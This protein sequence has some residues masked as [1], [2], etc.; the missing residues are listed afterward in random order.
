M[1]V[2]ISWSGEPSR[3]VALFL[4]SWLPDLVQ[5][6]DPWMSESDLEA[7]ARWGEKIQK[8]LSET[9]FGIVCVTP[10][11]MFAPWL[12]FESGALA[13]TINYSYV[14]PYLIGLDPSQLKGPLTQF[15]AKV[16][17]RD[18]TLALVHTLNRALEAKSL[19]PDRIDRL[20]ERF[21]P[22]LEKVLDSLPPSGDTEE[23]PRRTQEDILEEVL[24]LVRNIDKRTQPHQLTL[25][26]YF[27]SEPWR[28]SENADVARYLDIVTSGADRQQVTTLYKILRDKLAEMPRERPRRE[29]EPSD[30]GES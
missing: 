14:C 23:P 19:P 16:A 1:K 11:N 5:A 10:G 25:A 22:D 27:T 17:Q 8:E 18:E 24:L 13:K 6:V 20:F 30:E 9:S 28:S 3:T 4:R 29:I 7:G 12:L 21:W 15:Q 26:D 2:F